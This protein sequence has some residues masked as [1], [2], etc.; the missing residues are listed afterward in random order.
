[1]VARGSL[2]F[3][4]KAVAKALHGHE[5]IDTSWGESK[6]DGLGAMVGA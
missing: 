6:V 5:L 4:L 2:S 1:M 3:G